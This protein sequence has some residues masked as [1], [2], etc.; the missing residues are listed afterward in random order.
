MTNLDSILK[1]RDITLL[2]KVHVVKAIVFPGAMV[3][4]TSGM[5][6]RIVPDI[7]FGRCCTQTKPGC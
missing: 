5:D 2:T 4:L 3:F 6:V 7:S 1:N